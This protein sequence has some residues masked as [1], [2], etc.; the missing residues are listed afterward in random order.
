MDALTTYHGKFITFEGIEGSGKSTNIQYAAELIRKLGVDV[1]LTREP[2]GT[3]MGEKIRSVLLDHYDEVVF[4]M[5]EL[6]LLFAARNQHIENVIKPAL[7][8]G[9]C[10]LCDRFT[11]ASYAYQGG[12]RGLAGDYIAQLEDMVQLN[13]HPDLTIVFD[14]TVDVSIQRIQKR[15]K[16]DRIE[17]APLQFFSNVREVYL[18]R[19][20][21][22]SARYKVLD[23]TMPLL[24]VQKALRHLLIND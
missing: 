9:R 2:G 18:T 12:G 17:Q 10:V 8:A 14:V 21:A 20:K 15:K 1:V 3:A 4:P 24:A 13:L 7:A 11:D 6:L 5:T 23:A 19:A 16:M 22:N